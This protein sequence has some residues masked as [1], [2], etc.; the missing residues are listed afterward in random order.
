M[1]AEEVW[2]FTV[3]M[4]GR[5]GV[6]SLCLELQESCGLDVNMLLFMFCLGQN[7]LAPYSI[8]ALENAV[9]NWRE[10]VIVPLRSARRFLR[11]VDRDDAQKL[12]GKVKN[13]ELSAE[14]IEQKLLCD[15]V[16]TIPANDPFAPAHAYLSP[17]RF[18][19]SQSECDQ[20]LYLLCT[21]MGLIKKA[22]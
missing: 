11:N 9:R 13:D 6:A 14:R 4:Y 7:G 15:A 2:T 5:D 16:E 1:N 17:T 22:G 18:N 8:S 3:E 12:R 20:A 10:Q 19:L 21:R